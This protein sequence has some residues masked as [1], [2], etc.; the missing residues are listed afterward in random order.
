MEVARC[1][2]CS[3]VISIEHFTPASASSDDC[4]NLHFQIAAFSIL[5]LTHSP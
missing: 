2:K 3:R 4:D 5:Y 1:T